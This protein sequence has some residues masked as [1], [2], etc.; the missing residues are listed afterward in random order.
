MSPD[1]LYLNAYGSSELSEA[2]LDTVLYSDCDYNLTR[3]SALCFQFVKTIL[4]YLLP[5]LLMFCTHFKILK[6]LREVPRSTD[7]LDETEIGPQPTR[8]LSCSGY[9][10]ERC[11]SFSKSLPL[12]SGRNSALDK[13]VSQRVDV[14]SVDAFKKC[15]TPAS[16]RPI[17]SVSDGQ[18]RTQLMLTMNNQAQLESRRK[19]A[20]MLTA[21]VILF[22][23]SYLPVHL[24]N[25]LR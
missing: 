13:S 22:G 21:I 12:V 20:K 24:I 2:G 8:K 18:N 6:T 1:L 23:L 15:T 7:E 25:S 11:R 3:S 9:L 17:Q 14:C 16:R 10:A 19:A 4:L 5:F